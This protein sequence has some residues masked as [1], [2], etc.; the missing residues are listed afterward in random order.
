MMMT[1]AFRQYA[2]MY[3]SADGELGLLD[4]GYTRSV[5]GHAAGRSWHGLDG[6]LLNYLADHLQVDKL[7]TVALVL[8]AL[9]ALALGLRRYR[10]RLLKSRSVF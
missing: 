2:W 3:G 4:D 9:L 7:L 10:G 1:S 8:V 5:I 6:Y